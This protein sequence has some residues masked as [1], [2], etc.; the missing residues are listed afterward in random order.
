VRNNAAKPNKHTDYATVV[1]ADPV[2]RTIEH[3]VPR[4]S[5]WTETVEV[6]DRQRHA[7]STT[8]ALIG[9]LIGGAIGHELGRGK[10]NKKIG[11][12]VGSILGMSVGNDIR[13]NKHHNRGD[14]IRFEEIERCE[15]SHTI[16]TEEI[17][18]G[19]DVSY[20]YRGQHY[21][22]FMNEHPGRRIPVAVSVRPITR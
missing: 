16:E 21:E 19:Y 15:V 1:S 22:T 13:R 7:K 5:C 11:A 10:D 14:R 4:E 6:R 2:Y 12:V 18:Q 9:G 3:R 17:L 20:K 8:P